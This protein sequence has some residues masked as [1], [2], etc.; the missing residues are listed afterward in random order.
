VSFQSVVS[1]C[2]VFSVFRNVCE[3]KLLWFCFKEVTFDT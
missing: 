2:E 3:A 1:V